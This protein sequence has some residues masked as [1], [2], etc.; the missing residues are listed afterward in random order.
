MPARRAKQDAGAAESKSGSPGNVAPF[1][2]F[3]SAG[4]QRQLLQPPNV[5]TQPLALDPSMLAQALPS[6]N[7]L[8]QQALLDSVL[9]L[10]QVQ[11]GVAQAALAP[12]IMG[13]QSLAL[14]QHPTGHLLAQAQSQAVAHLPPQLRAQLL[15]SQL[16]VPQFNQPQL[17]PLLQLQPTLS[18]HGINIANLQPMQGGADPI[19]R[20]L[21]GSRASQSQQPRQR[22]PDAP[23]EGKR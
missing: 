20:A 8:A 7:P 3:P 21:L 23:E 14:Q 10:Q 5:G 16:R 18:A 17:H 4:D 11:G 13:Q 9:S 12:F 2:F 6:N 19:L 22:R 1:A 15:Q